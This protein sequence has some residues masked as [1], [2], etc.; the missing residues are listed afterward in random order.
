MRQKHF[1]HF[2]EEKQF[3]FTS[4]RPY[5]SMVTQTR[6]DPSSVSNVNSLPCFPSKYTQFRFVFLHCAS[7]VTEW[8]SSSAWVGE[9]ALMDSISFVSS[10]AQITKFCISH[11]WVQERTGHLC[12]KTVRSCILQPVWKP[13]ILSFSLLQHVLIWKE[14]VYRNRWDFR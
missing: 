8:R 13:Q 9:G 2:L 7:A 12:C 10:S 1:A 5:H 6:A 11:V 3:F 4:S 14:V